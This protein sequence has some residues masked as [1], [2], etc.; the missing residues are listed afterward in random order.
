MNWKRS[1]QRAVGDHAH[2]VSCQTQY[3]TRLLNRR[4]F[5]LVK[6]AMR[7]TEL[8]DRSSNMAVCPTTKLTVKINQK[9]SLCAR[10]RG[11]FRPGGG[12]IL[13]RHLLTN[14]CA[15]LPVNYPSFVILHLYSLFQ[16]L[17]LHLQFAMHQFLLYR[18]FPSCRLSTRPILS[19]YRSDQIYDELLE[20]RDTCANLHTLE[21][22][23]FHTLHDSEHPYSTRSVA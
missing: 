9:E 1:A 20:V 7:Y 5:T 14:D 8:K 15:V 12:I 21:N 19:Q 13:S 16:A 17:H 2:R 22:S 10:R 4:F 6:L 11:S 3:L 23:P 18:L